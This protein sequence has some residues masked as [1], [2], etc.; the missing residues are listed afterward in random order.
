MSRTIQP[1][2]KIVRKFS[3]NIFGSKKFDKILAKKPNKPGM[4]GRK[5]MRRRSSDYAGQLKEKQKL[6]A[7][8][9]VS[10]RQFR[11]YYEVARKTQAATGEKLLQILESRLDNIVYRAGFA[12][13][14]AMARQLVNH[15]HALVEGQRV[16]I[17]SCL[18]KVGQVVSLSPKTASIPQIAKLLENKE[19]NVPHWLEKK[20]V[21]VKFSR[22]PK[23]EEIDVNIQEQL[24]VEF[25]SR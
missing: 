1:R 15:G 3:E 12:T 9:D 7:I 23:R 2:A 25:Y 14:R 16:T 10:E 11:R 6:R 24:I 5:M 13:T 21:L 18:I 20:A 4:H 8:Y 19:L 22:L 17:P